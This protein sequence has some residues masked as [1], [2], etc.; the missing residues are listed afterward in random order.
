MSAGPRVSVVVAT[1]NRAARLAELLESLRA[2]RLPGGRFEVVVVDDGSS[3]TTAEVLE[4]ECARGAL[5]LRTIARAVAN[6]PA[7]ARNAGWH[8]ASAPLIAFTDDDCVVAD[9]WL[10][11]GLRACVEHPEAIVQGRTDP[12]PAE[13]H[14]IGAFSRTLTIHEA[15]PYYQTCNIFYPRDV[16]ERLGGFDEEAFSLPKGEDTDLAWRALEAGV[17]IVYAGGTRVYHA[18]NQLGAAGKLKLAWD[19]SEA[20][21]IFARHPG[22]RRRATTLGIFWKQTHCLLFRAILGVLAV[23]SRRPRLGWWLMEPYFRAVYARAKVEGGSLS[24]A[25]FYLALDAVEVAGALRASIR[26]RM[27]LL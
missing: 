5:D 27:L 23:R 25:P 14:S 24:T 16:L 26:Y 7:A 12:N 1:H 9:D 17:P 20:H 21:Q 2:L 11:A 6:G 13:A 19:W 4:V 15:G 18:V 10:E 22:L 3:D 8:A